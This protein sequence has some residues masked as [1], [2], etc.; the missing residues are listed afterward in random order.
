MNSGAIDHKQLQEWS[1]RIQVITKAVDEKT[2]R[3]LE[4]AELM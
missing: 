3:W 2:L 1:A 4:L